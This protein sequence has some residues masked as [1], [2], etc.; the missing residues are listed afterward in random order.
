MS[1]V[2]RRAWLAGSLAVT[3]PALAGSVRA[4][5]PSVEASLKLAPVQ[6]EVEYDRPTAEEAAK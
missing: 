5:A 6:K 2:R 1:L 3:L 4:D